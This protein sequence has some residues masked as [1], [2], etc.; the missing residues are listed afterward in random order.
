MIIKVFTKVYYLVDFSEVSSLFAIFVLQFV[1]RVRSPLKCVTML[2][3]CE[4]MGG[5]FLVSQIFEGLIKNCVAGVYLF[6]L[7]LKLYLKVVNV[8]QLL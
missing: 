4:K 2:S 8:V 7:C 1:E 6:I 3:H 5:V